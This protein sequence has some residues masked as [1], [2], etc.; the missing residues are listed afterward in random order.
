MM[1]INKK[2]SVHLI[3]YLLK[4]FIIIYHYKWYIPFY[5]VK[6]LFEFWK[7][8]PIRLWFFLIHL[9]ILFYVY[10]DLRPLDMVDKFDIKF[11]FVIYFFIDLVIL[12]IKFIIK[13]K[14]NYYII[15]EFSEPVIFENLEKM[16]LNKNDIIKIERNGKFMSYDQLPEYR[17]IERN[18]EIILWFNFISTAVFTFLPIFWVIEIAK[19]IFKFIFLHQFSIK[20]SEFLDSFPVLFFT[21]P[22]FIWSFLMF[23]L[24]K[25]R[26][27]KGFDKD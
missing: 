20:Q 14:L 22:I 1:P 12:I 26:F 7:N 2:N 17:R 25:F 21:F 19:F 13:N 3:F 8:K 15:N 5:L 24:Q 18:K 23:L 16:N 9:L 4:I 11:L 6:C 27:K 10:L